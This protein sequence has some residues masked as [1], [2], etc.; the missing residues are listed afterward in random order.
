M[1]SPPDNFDSLRKVLR[2]KRFE[3]PPPRYFNEFSSRVLSRIEKGDARASWWERFGFDVRPA[4][5]AATGVLACALVVYG[6]ATAG[7]DEPLPNA[8]GMNS[9][10]GPGQ[11]SGV[12]AQPADALV[13]VSDSIS[14]N[15]TNP[16]SYGTPID[17]RFFRSQI[18]PVSFQR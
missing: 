13:A 7:G 6:V 11:S 12:T 14:V 9:F 18:M 8:G 2:V 16:V 10:V 15:S 3:Q 5:G 4:L 17:R 1:G